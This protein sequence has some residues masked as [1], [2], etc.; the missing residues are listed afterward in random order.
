MPLAQQIF[1][2]MFFVISTLGGNYVF[3][4]HNKR[5]NQSPGKIWLVY[6]NLLEFDRTDWILLL[7]VC[8]ASA[9][10][11]ALALMAG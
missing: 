10:C 1:V 8:A 6:K 9:L 3:I 11:I 7:I 4:R 5:S 2:A